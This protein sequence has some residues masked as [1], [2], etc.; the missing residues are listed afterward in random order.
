[1]ID[2]DIVCPIYKNPYEIKRFCDSLLNQE[3]VHIVNLV[4]PHTLSNEEVDEEI[5]KLIRNYNGKSFEIKKDEFSHSLTR[6]KAVRDYCTSNIVVFASED[7]V[8]Y[9]NYSLYNLVSQI[10]EEIVYAY[11]KQ[12]CK[13]HSIERYTRKF[14]YGNK[15]IIVSKDDIEKLQLMAFFASDAFSAINR[16]VFL[17]VNGYNNYNVMMNEDQ[18]YAKII[19][20][21]GYKKMYVSNALCI[22]SHKYTLKRLYRRYYRTGKFYK[23]IKIFN[24]YKKTNAGKKMALFV[25]KELLIHFNVLMLFRFP[26]DMMARYLGL[27]KGQKG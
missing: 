4:F 11:G 3:N 16:D 15:D 8:L 9:D 12:I 1:M 2:V 21:A 23:D 24:E 26:F 10:N 20:D 22:H 25:F 17:K 6:E 13:N 7:I 19:L 5:R 27:R 14:N 18:L